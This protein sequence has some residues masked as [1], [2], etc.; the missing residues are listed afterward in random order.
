LPQQK[1]WRWCE[2]C[3]GLFY[4]GN[5]TLGTCPAGGQHRDV[6]SDDYELVYDD[7]SAAGQS[8]WQWCNKC[9]GLAFAGNPTPGPCPAGGQHNHTGSFDYVLVNNAPSAQG[10][11]NWQWCKK[12]Q[13]LAFAGNASPGNCPAGGVHDHTGSANFVLVVDETP[14]PAPWPQQNLWRWCNKC[15]G[16]F[17]VGNKSLGTCPAGGQHQDSGSDDYV[18]IH[19]APA[20]ALASGQNNWQWCNKCQGLAFAGN[21]TPGPCPAGGQHVHTDSFNYLL[22]NNGSA[23]AGKIAKGQSNWQRCDKCQGLAFAGNASPGNCPAG[24]QHVHSG[25]SNYLLEIDV[26]A[27]PPPAPPAVKTFTATWSTSGGNTIGGTETLTVSSDGTWKI[28]FD[29]WNGPGV[30]TYNYQIRAYLIGPNV[31]IILLSHSASIANNLFSRVDQPYT[32]SGINPLIAMYWS[33]IENSA[34]LQVQA[35]YQP[36]GVLG[37]LDQVVA[38]LLQLGVGAVGGAVGA[39]IALTRE[40]LGA[41]HAA[42]GAGTTI[43]VIAGVAV[44]VIGAV[45]GLGIGAAAL[46]GT[47]AGAATGAVANAL[48]QTRAMTPTEIAMAQQVF[49]RELNCDNVMF[50]N[51]SV[52]GRAMTAP[53]VDGKTYCNFGSEFAADMSKVSNSAYPVAGEVMIHELTHA[54]QIQ[55]NSFIPGFVCSG[56][57]NQA[58]YRFGDNIYRYG[59][60][61]PPWNSFNLEQQ[62][63]IVNEWFAGN[64]DPPTLDF[65]GVQSAFPGMDTKNPYYEYLKQ[66]ILTGS[67]GFSTNS[68]SDGNATVA[69]S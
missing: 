69:G 59:P 1:L 56:M 8:N 39:I 9:Q 68:L 49:Q 61:G 13:G 58:E 63:S 23:Q 15:Q 4:V 42:L 57:I 6:A 21:P 51:F 30:P 66:N 18:L 12:C 53:G 10:Q 16:L 46:V 24:G 48:I 20:A 45:A 25:S 17:Y 41:L 28:D 62:A 60:P 40:A 27:P 65:P 2:K 44:F 52:T 29:T 55:H 67:A 26:P 5:K 7:P 47:V 11:S 3:Q 22:L 14:P 54:W 36:S 19:D 38:D 64:G 31:P 37:F 50:T 43:G 32:E 35:D 34:T 33:S